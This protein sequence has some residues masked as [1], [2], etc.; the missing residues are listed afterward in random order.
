MLPAAQFPLKSFDAA[1]H[2]FEAFIEPFFEIGHLRQMNAGGAGRLV[3]KKFRHR[4]HAGH[5]GH[6]D[7]RHPRT[8]A[9]GQAQHPFH[10]GLD[11]FGQFVQFLFGDLPF[12]VVHGDGDLGGFV[13]GLGDCDRHVAG[14]GRIGRAGGRITPGFIN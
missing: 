10:M 6:D 7:I 12:F 3:A 4:R 8:G 13:A 5:L 2:F 14:Q 9:H 11:F 1:V